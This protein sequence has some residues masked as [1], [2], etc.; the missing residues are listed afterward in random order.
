MNNSERIIN[1]SRYSRHLR[2][3]GF[4]KE[5]Q[6]RLL[7]S[8]V[9]IIGAGGL[10]SPCA[11]YL[12]AAGVG[13]IGLVDGDIVSLSNLQR[14]VIHFSDDVGKDKVASAA[15]KMQRMNPD[16]KVNTY[17]TFFTKD[18][19]LDL[20]ADYDFILDCT[21]SF[22]SKY[23]V[24]D[25]CILAGKP[26]CCGGVVKYAG[27]IMTH[28]PGTACYRCVFPEPPSE[29]NVE[30][31]SM[32]GVLSPAVGIMGTIQATEAVKYIAGIGTLLADTLLTFD[33]LSM[34][35][36]RFD[37][38]RNLHCAVCG[39]TPTIHELKEISALAP[40]KSKA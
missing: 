4:G 37:V 39:D 1:A 40:C 36:M 13:T 31:C 9:L 25:A 33:T 3:P 11:L 27:Q 21:D 12:A 26:F 30:T 35:F 15:E 23:L 14:Q 19:A 7:E 6:L 17:P 28:V 16:V 38:T 10:G 2:L 29:N 18:N 22:A 20:I 24:N 34:Q 8:K 32:V 5:G